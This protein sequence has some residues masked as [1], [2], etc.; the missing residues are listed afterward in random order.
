MTERRY[1]D[2]SLLAVAAKAV[3]PE[4]WEIYQWETI[5]IDTPNE[6]I[7]VDGTVMRALFVRGPRKGRKNFARRERDKDMSFII[8][9][10]EIQQAKAKWETETGFC[11]ECYGNGDVAW[12]WHHQE[13]TKFKTCKKCSGTGKA[14]S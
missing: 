4:G 1:V 11:G 5:N 12:S 9:R 13:G 3:L 10:A 7:K 14:Q 8:T 6:A 2:F